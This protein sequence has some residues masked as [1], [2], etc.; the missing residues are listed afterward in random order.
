M[1][2]LVFPGDILGDAMEYMPGN[3]TI[4]IDGKIVST[5]VGIRSDDEE[6]K[7]IYVDPANKSR[8]SLRKGDMV[9]ARATRLSD[10]S[11][12]ARIIKLYSSSRSG[13]FDYLA[14][15]HVRNMDENY[16]KSAKDLYSENDIFLARIIKTG[17]IMELTT[18]GAEFGVIFSSCSHCGKPLTS[19]D[20]KL[21]CKDCELYERKKVSSKYGSEYQ[22]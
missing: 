2:E 1:T 18:K 9:I 14:T 19:V 22:I 20:G 5:F 7:K 3:G 8:T 10:Y 12:T 4:E 6:R 17:P 11:V 16:V 13:D 21:Y 15:L